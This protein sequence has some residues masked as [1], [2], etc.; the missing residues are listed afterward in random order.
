MIV[1]D[2]HALIW[3]IND[4]QKLSQ[5][6][7]KAIDEERHKEGSLLVSSISTLEIYRLVKNGKLQLL[8]DFDSWLERIE[9][10][11]EI[12][13]IPVDNKIAISSINLSDFQHKDPADR[14]I[15]ATALS[16]GAKLVTS[17]NK[18]VSYKHIQAIW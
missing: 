5:K 3:W 8:N 10:L 7:R 15:I 1:L 11:P 6:A 2:T 12:R 14:I 17:D 18:I 9:S 16:L 4:P 13:F